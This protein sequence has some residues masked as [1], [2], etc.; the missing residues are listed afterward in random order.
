[1]ER[2]IDIQDLNSNDYGK[3]LPKTIMIEKVPY[4]LHSKW[5]LMFEGRPIQAEYYTVYYENKNG[6]MILFDKKESRGYLLHIMERTLTD[7]CRKMLRIIE[8]HKDLIEITTI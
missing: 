4:D 5:E 8:E 3:Q 6:D 7:A 1:M 2:Y